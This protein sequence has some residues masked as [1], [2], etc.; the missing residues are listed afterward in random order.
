VFASNFPVVLAAVAERLLADAGVDAA[1]AR[2]AVR[3]LLSSAAANLALGDDAALAL[4]GPV[5]RG[6]ATTVARHLNALADDG[7]AETLYRV[8]ARATLR[9]AA[10]AAEPPP[11]PARDA[12]ARLLDGPLARGT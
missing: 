1:E 5:A 6:D 8:L 12:I 3:H 4:T 9:L 11:A 10:S 2:P 7:E